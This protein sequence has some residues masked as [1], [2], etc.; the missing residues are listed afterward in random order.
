MAE[1]WSSRGSGVGRKDR[2]ISGEEQTRRLV[3][4]SFP[5]KTVLSTDYPETRDIDI[6][7]QT[8]NATQTY[9]QNVKP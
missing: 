8:P 9:T 1:P 4:N 6:R 7:L 3:V 5:A 2:Q